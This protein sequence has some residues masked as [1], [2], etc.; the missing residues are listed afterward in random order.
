MCVT[1]ALATLLGEQSITFNRVARQFWN[2][3]GAHKPWGYWWNTVHPRLQ[4]HSAWIVKVLHCTN[5]ILFRK[6]K[7]NIFNVLSR[8]LQSMQNMM[9]YTEIYSACLGWIFVQKGFCVCEFFLLCIRWKLNHIIL[10]CFGVHFLCSCAHVGEWINTERR[11]GR[12]SS[13]LIRTT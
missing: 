2:H 9:G 12:N 5:S 4:V 6:A 11:Q 1:H 7:I 10:P 13:Q 3:R 8:G